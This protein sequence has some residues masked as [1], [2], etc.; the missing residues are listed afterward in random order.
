MDS[1]QGHRATYRN[2]GLCVDRVCQHR[3]WSRLSFHNPSGATFQILCRT[4]AQAISSPRY[5]FSEPLL[6]AAIARAKSSRHVSKY[7]QIILFWS[8][9]FLSLAL[10]LF[11]AKS[12]PD[13][14]RGTIII[15][16][17]LG[18]LLLLVSHIWIS[19]TLK[20]ALARATLAGDRAITIGDSEAVRDLSPTSILQKAGARE[21]RRYL[22]PSLTG[23]DDTAGLRL[24]R[25]L[26]WAAATKS[27]SSSDCHHEGC[28]FR[29][30][31]KL[32]RVVLQNRVLRQ[33]RCRRRSTAITTRLRLAPSNT[34]DGREK[35][36][37]AEGA[38]SARAASFELIR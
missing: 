17:I 29:N 38:P 28:F 35:Q 32:V 11:L 13:F 26:L 27:C 1:L 25:K 4:W 23:S 24:I 33:W 18:F 5:S 21:I 30:E 15:F 7:D 34:I 14:S 8:L 6:K 22:L 9:A 19:A 31:P 37:G 10:F 2:T 20:G 12:G 36:N 16:G 3:G